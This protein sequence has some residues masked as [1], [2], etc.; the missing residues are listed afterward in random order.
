MP[1]VCSESAAIPSRRARHI[2]GAR[3]TKNPV[4]RR[5]HLRDRTTEPKPP[6][7]MLD[8]PSPVIDDTCTT[9]N[10]MAFWVGWFA[11]FHE[12]QPYYVPYELK[13]LDCPVM[14]QDGK[15]ALGCDGQP[16]KMRCAREVARR[17]VTGKVEWL[18]I[19]WHIGIPGV[20]FRKCS[21]HDEAM[22]AFHAPPDPVRLL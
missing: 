18:M 6:L 15:P 13:M 17:E 22:T 5:A 10:Q 7:S 11:R 8:Q 2:S 9:T 20:T 1:Q 3:S 4:P 14:H 19:S 12:D 16:K 21:S